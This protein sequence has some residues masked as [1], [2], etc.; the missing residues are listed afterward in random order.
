MGELLNAEESGLVGTGEGERVRGA[1]KDGPGV[2]RGGMGTEASHASC[3]IPRRLVV[4]VFTCQCGRHENQAP[5]GGEAP[6]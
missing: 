4:S 5:G 2:L 3:W 1:Q 6:G